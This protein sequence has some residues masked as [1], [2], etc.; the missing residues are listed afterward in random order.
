VRNALDAQ[1]KELIKAEEKAEL[2]AKHI[3]T[4]KSEVRK[5]PPES[6]GPACFKAHW[7]AAAIT[8]T[9]ASPSGKA[10][11]PLKRTVGPKEDKHA[12]E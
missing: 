8:H 3:R 1:R 12:T 5:T 4:R 6:A 11:N 2:A 10:K 9:F 7:L